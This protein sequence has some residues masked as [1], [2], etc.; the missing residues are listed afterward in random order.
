[1]SFA[2]RVRVSRKEKGYSQ[3]TLAEAL[4]VSRQTVTK[5]ETENAYPEMKTLLL[6][7]VILEKDLDW[8]FNDDLLAARISNN[9][10]VSPHSEEIH[11]SANKTSVN[12]VNETTI[13]AALK[14]FH[15]PCKRR[16]LQTGFDFIDE[17]G[18][19]VNKVYVLY[20]LAGT[21]K[22]AFALN[23][24]NNILRAQGKAAFFNL[25]EPVST[26]VKKLLGI[27]AG[28]NTIP[29][30][31]VFTDDDN[32]K[33]KKAGELLQNSELYMEQITEE[34]VEKI[35]EKCLS[36]SPGLDLIVID[37]ADRLHSCRKA[38]PDI[39]R[40]VSQEL[41]EMAEKCTCPVLLLEEPDET[42]KE[43]MKKS[44]YPDKRDMMSN[45]EKKYG[46]KAETWLLQKTVV[47]GETDSW[48]KNTLTM[49]QKQFEGNT[50]KVGEM[51]WIPE[52]MELTE[53]HKSSNN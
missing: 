5:W 19:M 44:V 17:D 52:T 25:S 7:S 1:M 21:G 15:I 53:I 36:I 14:E 23:V 47:V 24:V 4:N 35:H 6:L 22:T 3:E 26:T 11:M 10:Y 20:G 28:V 37:N 48:Y 40:Q 43:I 12:K 30:R 9:Y 41:R 33:L 31:A 16:A 29:G 2:E 38:E 42:A 51:Q 18:G 45:L 27:S 46:K 8:L 50:V 32:R 34:P 39:C 49:K 13:A